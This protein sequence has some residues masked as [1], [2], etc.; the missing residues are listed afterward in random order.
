MY[1]ID[2]ASSFQVVRPTSGLISLPSF[3]DGFFQTQVSSHQ[4]VSNDRSV[5]HCTGSLGPI[6]EEERICPICGHP[7]H[8]KG[9]RHQTLRH[10]PF[11]GSY[12]HVSFDV[13]R[14]YCEQCGHSHMRNIPFKAE[15]HMITTAL[16]Q[17]VEDLLASGQFTLK[18]IVEMCGLGQQTVSQIDKAKLSR[19]YIEET[20]EG[21]RLIKPTTFSECLAI[22]EFKLHNHYQYVTHII[23]LKTGHV[24]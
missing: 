12:T 8:I 18:A 2:S 6:Q 11:G 3:L 9:S 21:P 24:L 10:I 14:F 4:D 16:K 15:H 13:C 19:L 20:S 23:D 1:F 17:Y 5:L 22:D 7:M